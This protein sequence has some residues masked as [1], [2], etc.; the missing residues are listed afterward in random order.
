M[1]LAQQQ[2]PS[3][4]PDPLPP[5]PALRGPARATLL[6]VNPRLLF[7]YWV[8]DAGL[9]RRLAAASGPAQVVIES[10]A[11]ARHGA[12][13]AVEPLDFRSRSWY[14]TLPSL[15]PIAGAVR[16]RLGLVEHGGFVELLRSNSV[17]IPRT[18]PGDAPE[19][20]MDRRALRAGHG[21]PLPPPPVA[22][23]VRVGAGVG[24]GA[25]AGGIA[26][27]AAS[28]EGMTGAGGTAGMAGAGS[29]ATS[30]HGQ[31][32]WS[33]PESPAPIPSPRP[34]SA[35][36]AAWIVGARAA[37]A[38]GGAGASFET[39]LVETGAT[40]PGPPGKAPLPPLGIADP[41]GYLT[42]VLHAHLP[43]VRHPEREY[44]LEEQWLFEGIT[45]TYLPLLDA[46]DHLAAERVPVRLT[47]SVSPTLAAMLR[48]PL[49]MGKYERHL[50]RLCHLAWREVERTRRDPAF[51]PVAGF[52]WDRLHRLEHLFKEVYG[53]DLL[54]RLAA[55]EDAGVVEVITCAATHGF[56]PHHRTDPASVRAQVATGVA[57]HRRHFGRSPRGLWLP[58]CA[59]FE[60]LDEVLAASGIEYFFVDTHGIGNAASAPRYG[61]HAPLL[62]PTG[63]AA[64]GRDAE[65]STQVW[66]SEQ[67]YP[68]DPAYRDF[69]RDIGYDLDEHY[70]APYLD[71]A[72]QRGMTGFKYHRITGRTD[73]KEPYRRDVA[74]RTATWHADDFVR[75]RSL[76][77]DWLADG[78]DRPP[79]V[80]SMYDAE[81][82][83]H[84][85]FEGPDWI[86]MVLRRLPAAGIAVISPAQYLE[87][88][89]V[90]QVARPGE[91]SWGERG[92]HDVWLT[93]ANDWILPPLH[94]AAGRMA[95][96]ARRFAAADGPPARALKQAGRELLLAQSSDW[97]FIL[98]NQT[99]PEYA[100][101]RVH[102]HLDRFARLAAMLES[103]R[104][105]SQALAAIEAQDDLFPG[106][107][108]GLWSGA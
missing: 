25:G 93:G 90:T 31:A 58:E 8:V 14:L 4:A 10:A 106:L 101:R 102:L 83:G 24:A 87:E 45:E 98:R 32:I 21:E 74:L 77:I 54:G 52:Y 69:Y 26:G 60:G 62:C 95:D 9:E 23:R 34:S 19:L 78:M 42:F 46:L 6:V 96:L 71:P 91:S 85:W 99:T 68:G 81:L 27:W 16:A 57:E 72:G 40:R 20:W 39:I 100:R 41:K 3:R 107:E 55:L 22:R 7:L 67:G 44:F 33:R 49:L 50:G 105:D 108:P 48:D 36:D 97:P 103:G 84:W 28:A 2:A 64:F 51:S 15:P 73:H 70:V 88:H 43:F 86:E 66:S 5:L 1:P 12:I 61:V 80:V 11:G 38:T 65:S 59:Y 30:P 89:P 82:F 79:L 104:I 18:L 35:P 92:Y 37:G 75:N 53:R 13:V 76:Q 63:V 29:T 94:D 47:I 17:L 56:L